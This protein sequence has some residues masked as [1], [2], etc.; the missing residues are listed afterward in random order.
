MV[1]WPED[2]EENYEPR[3]VERSRGRR[4][5][6]GSTGGSPKSSPR[7]P[8]KNPQRRCQEEPYL[9]SPD[10]DIDKDE[11]SRIRD[12]A[13]HVDKW[14]IGGTLP[15]EHFFTQIETLCR[16]FRVPARHKAMIV[17]LKCDAEALASY[18][19]SEPD[20]NLSDYS[21]LKKGLCAMYGDRARNPYPLLKLLK[22]KLR[23]NQD[24]QDF[25]KEFLKAKGKVDRHVIAP[26][27]LKEI[28]LNALDAETMAALNLDG[29]ETF[30]EIVVQCNAKAASIEHARAQARDLRK[31]TSRRV[32]SLRPTSSE[33]DR[34]GRH[35]QKDD[36]RGDQR[37]RRFSK[38]RSNGRPA[39]KRRTFSEEE[40]AK[41]LPR[42]QERTRG[43]KKLMSPAPAPV[44]D[45]Q[46]GQSTSSRSKEA[47]SAD[48]FPLQA[49]R[50][51]E[52]CT[53]EAVPEGQKTSTDQ[54]REVDKN[55]AAVTPPETHQLQ[56][57]TARGSIL[58][59]DVR[60]RGPNSPSVHTRTTLEDSRGGWPLNLEERQRTEIPIGVCKISAE[61]GKATR[62]TAIVAIAPRMDPTAQIPVRALID[63]GAQISIIDSKLL[64]DLGSET[65]GERWVQGVGGPPVRGRRTSIWVEVPPVRR[66]VEVTALDDVKE[67]LILGVPFLRETK[68]TISWATD[69]LGT[70][71]LKAAPKPRQLQEHPFVTAEEVAER[72]TRPGYANY[73]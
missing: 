25:T 32:S 56:P 17:R 26:D 53:E 34:M 38:Q 52:P 8:S 54:D 57:T 73:V 29:E 49:G 70:L 71:K 27:G 28:F 40:Q 46:K 7:R 65:H 33:E 14:R 6:D 3:R 60:T 16:D 24:I 69:K 72:R 31:M 35:T 67:G 22:Y 59:G 42:R 44:S 1:E 4:V 64:Q 21:A 47:I 10:E 11:M 30:N 9:S 61:E 41:R 36:E 51:Q 12:V 39:P 48:A 37:D 23:D 18:M 66:L 43:A 55:S 58:D 19:Q 68:A 13:K 5:S 63:S 2:E 62:P 15:L 50:N 20:V 45:P